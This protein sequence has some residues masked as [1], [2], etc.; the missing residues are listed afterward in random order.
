MVNHSRI[1]SMSAVKLTFYHLYFSMA[2]PLKVAVSSCILTKN[3]ETI[4]T[5]L[6]P[7]GLAVFMDL[8]L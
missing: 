3:S 5:R 1:V 7:I 8:R 4:N 6:Q 2:S